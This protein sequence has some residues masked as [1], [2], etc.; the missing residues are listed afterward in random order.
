MFKCIG[1]AKAKSTNMGMRLPSKILKLK[2]K[3]KQ[4]TYWY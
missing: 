2:P 4:H 1:N 3:S